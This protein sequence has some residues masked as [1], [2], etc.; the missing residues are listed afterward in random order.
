MTAINKG[1]PA[2]INNSGEIAGAGSFPVAGTPGDIFTQAFTY[3]NGH[4]T[5]LGL[6]P[7]EGGIF[8]S[9]SGINDSG[10]VA[11]SGD[12][13]ASDER[14]WEYQNGT[15]TD[16]GTLGGPQPSAAAI[17]AG[18]PIVGFAQTSTDADDGF[19]YAGGKMTDLGL[20]VFPDAINDL[21]VIAG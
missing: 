20:N 16:I 18:V 6:L 19:L 12:N 1:T 9:A 10:V 14:A 21:G 15:M 5:V 4:T 17:N 2:A 13:A 11:G 8:T 7:G 3:Q